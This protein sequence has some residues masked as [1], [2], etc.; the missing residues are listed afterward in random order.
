MNGPAASILA[1]HYCVPKHVLGNVELIERFG[2]RAI[3]AIEKMSG[4][5][6]RRIA[7]P[8]VTALDLAHFAS[9]QLLSRSGA[10]RESIDAVI[11]CSQTSDYT[12]PPSACV[13]HERLKLQQDCLSF[14]VQH[15]CPSFAIGLSLAKSLIESG[16]RQNVLLVNADTLT[17]LI[18]PDDRSL[19]PLHGDG[20]AVMVVGQAI[21]GGSVGIIQHGTDGSGHRHLMV[22][23]SG[24]R[25][26]EPSTEEPEHQNG[27]LYMN[28]PAVFQFSLHVVPDAI[29]KFLAST[30]NVISDYSSIIFHQ[31]NKMMLDGIYDRILA[32][33]EQRFYFIESV[34]NTSAASL[35][36]A[37]AEAARTGVVRP[38]S[39]TLFAAFG[40]GLA[41]GVGEI[42]WGELIDMSTAEVDFQ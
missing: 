33:V 1:A 18:S 5:R 42:T 22:P 28:G 25:I 3:N 8:G 14:D 24:S 37:L 20:A 2:A 36:M 32:T 39:R 6:E 34:G 40:V 17:R 4:I 11:F 41:W 12:I 13:L 29:N 26:V 23:G 21:N 10:L 31:A 30:G 27:F 16:A 38:G 35:P 15:G 19:I 9:E 7:A